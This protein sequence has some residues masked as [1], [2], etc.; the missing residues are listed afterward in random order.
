MAMD[1]VEL[2]VFVYDRLLEAGFPPA[3]SEI[4]S[5]FGVGVADAKRALAELKVGKTILVHP[6]SGELWM[7]G[8]F[9]SAP[10]DYAVT[11]SAKWFANCAWDMLGIPIIAN[12]PVRIE[13][14]C[15]HCD[16]ALVFTGYPDRAPDV[17]AI[18]HFLVPARKWYDDIGFT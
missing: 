15:F 10:T 9:A 16:D 11:G 12:E 13:T 3:T 7:A 2:R 14:K 4:A 8:P 17:D 18:V 5:H 6:Q 1:S